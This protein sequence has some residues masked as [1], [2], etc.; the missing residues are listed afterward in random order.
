MSRSAILYSCRGIAKWLVVYG[1]DRYHWI[2]VPTG[3]T[4]TSDRYFDST[5]EMVFS[6]IH[7]AWLLPVCVL[8]ILMATATLPQQ[9]LPV[10]I[11]CA[12][13][14]ETLAFAPTRIRPASTCP[15]KWRDGRRQHAG[16]GRH[17]YSSV[18]I[19]KQDSLYPLGQATCQVLAVARTM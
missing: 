18:P 11:Q 9:D 17:F 15:R 3:T 10:Y 14:D 8:R 12:H 6:G 13:G 2:E 19:V 4:S 16:S 7:G 5:K 1:E